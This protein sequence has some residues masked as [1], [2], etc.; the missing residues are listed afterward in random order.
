[1]AEASLFEAYVAELLGDVGDLNKEVSQLK[2]DLPEI[3]K[4]ISLCISA[5]AAESAN[6]LDGQTK[7]LISASEKIKSLIIE[8][9]DKSLASVKTSA[10]NAE[11]DAVS[12]VR[13]TGEEIKGELSEAAQKAVSEALRGG[14]ARLNKAAIA[15]S[16]ALTEAAEN[17]KELSVGQFFGNF[18][19]AIFGSLAVVAALYFSPL[20]T[21]IT[22]KQQNE[23][24]PAA[25]SQ[26]GSKSG[27]YSASFA[28]SMLD[29]KDQERIMS[30]IK[31]H[32]AS[33]KKRK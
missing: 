20:S 16:N 26:D 7:Q 28:V 11:N 15:L 22:N 25:S 17:K 31:Q 2:T 3:G 32:L 1:M 33:N 6:V 18:F 13:S 9:T 4:V 24:Q 5:A 29:A 30:E 8:A 27:Y 23:I 19:S 21:I 14:L 12:C 10:K